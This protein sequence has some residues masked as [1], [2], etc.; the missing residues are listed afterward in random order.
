MDKLLERIR[1]QQLTIDALLTGGYLGAKAK[2]ETYNGSVGL[3]EVVYQKDDCTIGFV[4]Y[5]NES[6][7]KAYEMPG[8]IHD[9]SIQT[10]Q[11]VR[12][13]V[14]M[15]ITNRDYPTKVV[16]R[17]MNEGEVC[18]IKPY[19]E[20]KTIPL[21]AGAKIVFINVPCERKFQAYLGDPSG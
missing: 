7:G 20:H 2:P 19:E 10:I 4:E 11:V 18:V 6:I 17:I 21:E 3:V 1:G 5:P 15:K 9:N 8:H 16:E 14:L 13:S 12:K